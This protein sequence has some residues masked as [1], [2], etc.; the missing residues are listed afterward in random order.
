MVINNMIITELY[1]NFRL[2]NDNIMDF[3][4]SMK[5]VEMIHHE[6][7]V[8]DNR[9]YLSITYRGRTNKSVH[10]ITIPKIDLGILTNTPPMIYQS[11]EFRTYDTPKI[12]IGNLPVVEPTMP[13]GCGK[14][15]IKRID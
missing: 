1:N 9:L 8:D 12:Y 5:D 4:L 15:I 6:T 7:I 10:E 13:D 2:L 14:I 11:E 3:I